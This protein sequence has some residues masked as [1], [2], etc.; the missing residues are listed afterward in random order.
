MSM[1]RGSAL[2][3]ALSSIA[4]MITDRTGVKV[5]R[6]KSVWTDKKAIYLP[7]LPDNMI[8]RKLASKVLGYLHHECGHV[9][10]SED[11]PVLG[12]PPV[13][14]A[15]GSVLED[16]RIELK[17]MR[18]LMS[19]RRYLGEMVR[20]LIEDGQEG[21]FG[22]SPVRSDETPQ[23]VL[24]YYMLYRLRHDVLQQAAIA[25]LAA[26]ANAV[27]ESTF[28]EGMKTRLDALMFEVESCESKMD[29]VELAGEIV[30]MIQEE[31][32]K[33][34][35]SQEQ[36]QQDQQQQQDQSGQGNGSQG[37]GAQPDDDGE[38]EGEGDQQDG[39]PGPNQNQQGS[40]PG[41]Q[42]GQ[43]DNN[44]EGGEEEAGQQ[45]GT[46]GNG[47]SSALASLQEILSMT[48]EE[49]AAGLGESLL[50][51][52]EEAS[53]EARG[54]YNPEAV[55][56]ATEQVMRLPNRSADMTALKGA[57]NAVRT[58]T[59]QWMSSVAEVDV[60]HSRS[61][62]LLDSSRLHMARLGGEVFVRQDEGIDLN[63]AIDILIDRSGSMTSVI[64][65][66][67]NAAAAAM[68]AFQVP[69]I[70]TRVSV[71]PVAGSGIGVV[72]RWNESAR[73][74]AGRVQALTADGGTPMAEAML[75]SAAGLVRREETLRMQVV[76]TDGMPDNPYSAKHVIEAARKEGIVVVALGI[77]VQPSV[78]F[79]ESH[80]A[81]IN[82]VSDLAGV[83][84]R[85][86]KR[87]F[88]EQRR[89]A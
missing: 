9:L 65:E 89:A 86:V 20:G 53:E 64:V 69:G 58:R 45:A 31:E 44:G 66:A 54:Q 85:L 38:E 60:Q 34:R 49:I 28:P 41:Q 18:N 47:A 79:G 76:I 46:G 78:V 51:E 11:W 27:A 35:E 25:Q 70:E 10:Y 22:F 56:M 48:E 3:A 82:S 5:V 29:V 30:K 8:G 2:W 75:W 16:I 4:G 12:L 24:Q 74:M 73:S 77:G 81:G 83:M 36:E 40:G 71:F 68:L 63:A 43:K 52:L 72:K 15:I 37:A 26:G 21:A 50:A 88:V 17:I 67:A 59:L 19:A 62:A 61:G 7:P 80:S 84:V 14:K 57:V 6:S 55:T 42:Q 13:H 87:A 1:I 39:Q 32:E 33:E 23:E